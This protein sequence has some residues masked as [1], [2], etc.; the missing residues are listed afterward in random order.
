[1]PKDR[2][3][4]P[5]VYSRIYGAAPDTLLIHCSL[6]HQGAWVPLIRAMGLSAVAFDMPGHGHSDDWDAVTDYQT[7]VANIAGTFCDEPMHIIGHSFGATV[8]LRVAL[9]HPD[10][11]RSL[12]LIEPVFFTAAHGTPEHEAYKTAFAPFVAAIEEGNRALA[13]ERFTDIWGA[14]VPWLQL[15]EGQRRYITDRIHLIRAG[16][17]AINGDNANQLSQGRLE[18]LEVPTLLLRGDLSDPITRAINATLG[19]RLPKAQS[20]VIKGVGHMGPI[21]DPKLYAVPIKAFRDGL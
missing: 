2:R 13:A 4:G 5:A 1:M 19:T 20:T 8:A 15:P 21:S 3:A 16:D 14:G 11:V 7:Q 18:A 17:P 6:A 9:D 12:T 10:R